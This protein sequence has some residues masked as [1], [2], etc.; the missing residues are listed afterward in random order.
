MFA[1]DITEYKGRPDQWTEYYIRIGRV[2]CLVVA[3]PADE[4]PKPAADAAPTPP[5]DWS[6][7]VA[8]PSAPADAAQASPPHRDDGW[9]DY[10]Q[11][12]WRGWESPAWKWQHW[13]ADHGADN[14]DTKLPGNTTPCV[15]PG[16][17]A[18]PPCVGGVADPPH[19]GGAAAP[20]HVE[21]AA[22]SH[23][24]GS[25]ADTS[26]VDGAAESSA[27]GSAAEPPPVDRAAHP[28]P[29]GGVADPP[30]VDSTGGSPPVGSVA[31]AAPA[32]SPEEECGTS[33]L[34]ASNAWLL[35]TPAEALNVD[36][37]NHLDYNAA[38]FYMGT[39]EEESCHE[40]DLGDDAPV[41]DQSRGQRLTTENLDQ[42]QAADNCPHWLCLVQYR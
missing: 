32:E 22:D 37:D 10:E 21:S 11:W 9:W 38:Q 20:P 16:A 29:M 1:H 5:A 3:P 23:P 14:T 33:P 7:I 17:C 34:D 15:H 28:P 27:V 36:G 30:R 41:A 6:P 39:P 42:E 18:D 25:A 12:N 19:V 31:E 4:A 8:G 24:V 40:V 35:D 13:S 2:R 26:P